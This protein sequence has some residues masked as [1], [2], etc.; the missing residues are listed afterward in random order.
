MDNEENDMLPVLVMNA[1]ACQLGLISLDTFNE[2]SCN[3][4]RPTSAKPSPMQ[5]VLDMNDAAIALKIINPTQHAQWKRSIAFRQDRES[6]AMQAAK[7]G[8]R[9]FIL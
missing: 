7:R 9:R 4:Q 1:V 3:Y 6:A 8:A 5:A 2:M